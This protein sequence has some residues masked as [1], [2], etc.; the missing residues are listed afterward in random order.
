MWCFYILRSQI[1]SKLYYGS[2]NDLKRRFNEHNA[3][4]VA[5]T[6]SRKPFEVVYYEAYLDESSARTREH[7]VKSSRGSRLALLKRIN[8]GV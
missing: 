1:D 7:K 3:G 6:N 8:I 2:T 4:K 5:S